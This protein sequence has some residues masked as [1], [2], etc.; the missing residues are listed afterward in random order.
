MDIHPFAGRIIVT[1]GLELF[2]RSSLPLLL[3][4]SASYA[5][6]ERWIDDSAFSRLNYHDQETVY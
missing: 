5:P 2:S 1:V 4:I 6:H 3:L